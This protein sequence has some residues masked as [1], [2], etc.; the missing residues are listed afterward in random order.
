MAALTSNTI[1]DTYLG[2]LKTSDSGARG[3]EGSADQ[4]SDGAGNTIPLYVSA[5]EIYAV[6]S[7]AGTSHTAFGKDCGVDLSTGTGNSLFGEGA[8]ADL[9]TGEHNVAVGYHALFQGTTES[10]DNVAIG[11]NAMSGAIVAEQVNDCIAIGSGA[12]A[13]DLD[14]TNGIDEASG[15][16]A[17]GASALAALITGEQNIAIGYQALAANATGGNN[18]MIGYQAGVS[19]NDAG[20]DANVGVGNFVF[21]GVASSVDAAGNTAIGYN[22]MSGVILDAADYN[23]CVGLGSG[24]SITSAAEC[25]LVGANAGDALTSGIK[26]TALGANALS[27]AD[28][29]TVNVAVGFNAMS[30]VSASE[31]IAGVVAIGY[32]ALKGSSSTTTGPQYSVAIGHSALK[33]ITTGASNTMVGFNAG[34]LLTTGASN[35][36]VGYT[37]FDAADGGEQGN[38]AIGMLAMS[39]VDEGGGAADNNVCI[40]Y[41]A[42]FGGATT[43]FSENVA[44]GYNAFD[45]SSTQ[46]VDK[47][48][49]IGYDA[50]GGAVEDEVTGTVAIGHSALAA[51]TTGARNLAIGYQAADALTTG[52]DNL[53]IG[54]SAL[55]S[56]TTTTSQNIAIGN[57][58]LNSITAGQTVTDNIAIGYHAGN[59]VTT[60]DSNTLVGMQAGNVITT[61]GT[62]TI[63]GKDADPSANSATNQIVIGSDTTGV[64]DNSV[65]LGNASVTDVFMSEDSSAYIHSQT[66]NDH[67]SNTMSAPYYRFDGSND[68]IA[69]ADNDHMS[70]GATTH[71]NPFSISAWINME[72]A[73]SFEIINKGTYNSDAEWIFH[74]DSSDK[75][76]LELFDESVSSTYEQTLTTTALT[77]Y[78]GKWIHVCATY[79]GVGGTSANA[80]ITLYLNGVSQAVTLAGAGTYVAMENLAEEV[81]IGNYNDA[82]YAEGSISKLQIFNL[83]LSATEVK[84]LYS[85]ASVPYKYKGSN[86]T[87]LITTPDFDG[88]SGDPFIPTGWSNWQSEAGDISGNTGA[89][90]VTFSTNA[91]DEGLYTNSYTL[92]KGQAYIATIVISSY[93]SGTL[94]WVGTIAD[95]HPPTITAAGTYSWVFI[96]T[97]TSGTHR[98]AAEGG[99]A[100]MT[101]SRF[102]LTRAGAVAEYD[103]SGASDAIW[104]DKSG[105]DLNGT[106]SGATLENKLDT[107]QASGIT[108]PATQHASSNANTLDDYEEGTW[109]GTFDGYSG[110]TIS[111]ET[112]T[113]IGRMVYIHCH[114]AGG[115]NTSG[116]QFVVL[117]LPFNPTSVNGGMSVISMDG[118]YAGA[119]DFLSFRIYTS[120]GTGK[121]SAHESDYTDLTYD[122]L[123]FENSKYVELYGW[124]ETAT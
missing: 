96:A 54:Y 79:N 113:K 48:V 71:D 99:A 75:L 119:Q 5:T 116:S 31:A 109:T 26:N 86:Q 63:I 21:D 72:D 67:V 57:Y 111:G 52:V 32:E 84:E 85:G 20:F 108:F 43:L 87:Q 33:S 74:V 114:C 101:M 103:G 9:T 36:V 37:A 22:S 76:C 44:I 25:V 2:L 1:A 18:T 3:A 28:T 30:D 14:S 61:G 19:A 112:Y 47:V 105:N 60:G 12:L 92:V 23:T 77:A 110:G 4:C 88:G 98:I 95:A 83:E 124:Y 41:N 62:N 123:D 106:V 50:L 58:A 65:T 59:A 97:G 89:G 81:R 66:V 10:D 15:T 27:T 104:Y 78:E 6:G 7:G 55:S 100:S 69:V 53:A 24:L 46:L 120:G 13:G 51:I 8:G 29:A 93:T 35:T 121:V 49:A 73:T 38:V 39:A 122:M 82:N 64:A 94:H 34:A 90:T 70:F 11:Y 17:I 80:G 117:G 42:G 68:E 102:S 56:A 118:N 16:V 40:G 91:G 115:G 45:G 107:I